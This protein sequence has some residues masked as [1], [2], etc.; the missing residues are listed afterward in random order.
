MVLPNGCGFSFRSDENVPK[1][2]LVRA[3]HICEYTKTH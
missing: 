2:T 3:A 1:L